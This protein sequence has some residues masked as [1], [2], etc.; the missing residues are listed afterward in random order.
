MNTRSTSRAFDLRGVDAETRPRTKLSRLLKK[1]WFNL[2]RALVHLRRH[3]YSRTRRYLYRLAGAREELILSPHYAGLR[4][5]FLIRREAAI[6]RRN[7]RRFKAVADAAKIVW[8]DPNSIDSK[9]NYDLD[10]CFN[11]ILPGDWDVLRKVRLERVAKHRSIHQRFVL[12]VAWKETDLFKRKYAARFARGESIRGTSNP[13][14]L[15]RKYCGQIDALFENMRR[16][17]FVI[18][19]D[20][21]GQLQSLPHLHIGRNGELILGNN[22]N[23]RIAIAKVLGLRPIPC[24]VRSSHVLWQQVR[25]GVPESLRGGCHMPSDFRFAGH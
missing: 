10:I 24:W 12:G 3:A 17:G 6:L 2:K 18:A 25:E 21:S 5:L 11:H 23:H 7:K 1:A 19:R 8:V 13:D 15:A 20:Q 16:N 9:L 22:G 4:G 14:D